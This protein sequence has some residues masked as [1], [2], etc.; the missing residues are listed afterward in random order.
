MITSFFYEVPGEPLF[1]YFA[2]IFNKRLNMYLIENHGIVLF[3]K[4]R[5]IK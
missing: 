4:E 3:K 2:Y 1:L 5:E